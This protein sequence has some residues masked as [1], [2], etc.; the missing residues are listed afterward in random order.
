MPESYRLRRYQDSKGYFRF[1]PELLKA[2]D[3]LED[4]GGDQIDQIRRV[5]LELKKENSPST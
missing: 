2:S 4:A 3:Y 5:A 1:F